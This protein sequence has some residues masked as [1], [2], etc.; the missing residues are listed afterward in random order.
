MSKKLDKSI[1][2][3]IQSPVWIRTLL[4]A[5]FAIASYFILLPLI[6][7]LSIAQ[8]L[9]TLITGNANANLKYFSAVL[10][11]Y[12]SQLFRFLTYLSEVKPYPFSNLPEV[13]DVSLENEPARKKESTEEVSAKRTT[14]K[15]SAAKK[16]TIKKKATKKKATKK[17]AEKK[18][19]GA[20][21]KP[22]TGA[23]NDGAGDS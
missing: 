13:E 4:V 16:K 12:I 7:V 19:S 21:N 15:E 2:N 6:I 18:P 11:L 1:D 17:K 22:E 20:A 5:F 8:G 9:F 23:E 3:V 10:E 14:A